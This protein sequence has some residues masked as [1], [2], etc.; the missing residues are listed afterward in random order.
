MNQ[1]LV[2]LHKLHCRQRVVR[3]V[4][5]KVLIDE[6]HSECFVFPSFSF[7]FSFP[8]ESVRIESDCGASQNFVSSVSMNG[9]RWRALSIC[10]Q[11]S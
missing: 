5:S 1:E 3:F 8:I 4:L 7:F 6:V 11:L 10:W 2:R 9:F